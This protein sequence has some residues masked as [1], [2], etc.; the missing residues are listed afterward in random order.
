MGPSTGNLL[1]L[2]LL[3]A[4]STLP[5]AVVP[6]FSDLKIKTRRSSQAGSLLEMLYLKEH[7]NGKSMS[8]TSL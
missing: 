4:S 7:G 2:F 6:N 1:A 8:T 5:H 3:L